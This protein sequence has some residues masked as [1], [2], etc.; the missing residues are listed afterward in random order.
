MRKWGLLAPI[1]L[2]L[3]IG[4]VASATPDGL[5]PFGVAVGKRFARRMPASR[6][7]CISG[8]EKPRRSG[9]SACLSK[10]RA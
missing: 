6:P 7:S 2:A 1:A 4:P 8:A 10:H 5:R 9:A 3:A